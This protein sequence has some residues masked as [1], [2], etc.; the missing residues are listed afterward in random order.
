MHNRIAIVI[1]KYLIKKKWKKKQKY[2]ANSPSYMI[3]HA[4]SMSI[5]TQ[6][7]IQMNRIKQNEWIPQWMNQIRII[8]G[9]NWRAT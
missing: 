2:I 3:F 1:W 7:T 8:S 9:F 6:I 4:I 5:S